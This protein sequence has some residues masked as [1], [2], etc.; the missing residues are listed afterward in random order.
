MEIEDIFP[1]DVDGDCMKVDPDK[2]CAENYSRTLD[3]CLKEIYNYMKTTCYDS[4]GR[5]L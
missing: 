4:D 3:I 2:I 5:L 1:M